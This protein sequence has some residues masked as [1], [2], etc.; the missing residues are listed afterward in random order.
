LHHRFDREIFA[1]SY[2]IICGLYFC[3]VGIKLFSDPAGFIYDTFPGANTPETVGPAAHI[4]CILGCSW[5]TSGLNVLIQ[6]F[7]KI[8]PVAAYGGV[9]VFWSLLT[10]YENCYGSVVGEPSFV[11]PPL[12]VTILSISLLSGDAKVKED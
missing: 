11:A 3:L 4:V 12:V 2:T 1:E 6:R 10:I 5:L 7:F 9:A 8:S